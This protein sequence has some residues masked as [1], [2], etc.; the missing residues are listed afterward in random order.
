MVLDRAVDARRA[1]IILFG[2][3]GRMKIHKVAR[4]L[5]QVFVGPIPDNKSVVRACDVP[6]CIR[7]RHLRVVPHKTTLA[8]WLRRPWLNDEVT[9][10]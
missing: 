5:Y 8:R 9:V 2:P 1:P 4:L 10:P 7:P 6:G 3:S